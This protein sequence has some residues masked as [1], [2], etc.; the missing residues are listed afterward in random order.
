MPEEHNPR[1]TAAEISVIWSSCANNGLS[2]CMLNYFL[3]N[4]DDPDVASVLE[5]ALG[6]SQ[7]D[8]Q[9]S[10]DILEKN[11]QPIP[12]GFREEDISP[13]APRLFSDAF[14]LYY[15]KNMAKVGLSVYGVALST[16]ADTDVRAFFSQAIQTSTELYNKTAAVLLDKGLFIRTPYVTTPDTVEFINSK[17]YISGFL[18][19]SKR[20]LNVIEIT[21][22][23]AN[24]ETNTVGSILLTGFSQVAKS[25]KVREYCRRGAEIA[26]KHI[27]IFAKLLTDDD[28]PAP[29]A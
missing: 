11:Q 27:N 29:M 14:Y 7:Y 25:K 9:R 19:T 15:L 20:P 26:K 12:I 6:I 16:A 22:I 18:T 3:A 24:V 5:F 28:L 1:L 4:V 10:K 23:E 13:N 21:H 17:D 2:V 8:L